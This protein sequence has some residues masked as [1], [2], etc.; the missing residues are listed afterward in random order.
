MSAQKRHFCADARM[1]NNSGIGV[2]IHH[3]LR[4]ILASDRFRVTLLGRKAELDSYF[5][6]FAN[7]QFIEADFPIYSVTEQLR[8]PRLIPACDLFWSPHYN[9]PLL[10]IRAKRHIVTIPDVYHLAFYNTLSMAQK[11]YARVVVNE[12]T[13]QADRLTTIS[14][15]SKEE[16]VR[17]TGVRASKI[18][19]VHLGVDTTL[20]QP[21]TDPD[22][23]QR[24]QTQYKLPAHYLLF[25]GNV[26]PNKNLRRLVEAFATLMTDHPDLYLVI[27]GKKEGFITG[28]PGLFERIEGNPEL[29]RR[30]SFTGYVSFDDLPV[31]YSLASL[32]VFPSIYEGF[33]FPPLEAMACGCAVVASN[34]TSIPEVCGDAVEYIDPHSIESMGQGIRRMLSNPDYRQDLIGKGFIQYRK[35]DWQQSAETFVN[36]LTEPR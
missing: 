30:V 24:V 25:V 12:A 23:R 26:K 32:F 11:L 33:G 13:R 29:A 9:I 8:L 17:F 21:V 36:L 20:F 18:D 27:T 10:P 15:Y 35:Y 16:I 7:W 2:Y 31:L 1:I 19:V 28:D 34:A 14:Q 3:Y 22:R 5:G 4:Y 6:T